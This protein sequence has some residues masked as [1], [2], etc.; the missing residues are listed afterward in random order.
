MA[1]AMDEAVAMRV[2][3]PTNR[4]PL[5]KKSAKA[6]KEAGYFAKVA[7]R[8]DQIATQEAALHRAEETLSRLE[9]NVASLAEGTER[10][11]AL[12]EVAEVSS[13]VRSLATEVSALKAKEIR[14]P[15]GLKRHHTAQWYIQGQSSRDF[16]GHSEKTDWSEWSDHWDQDGNIIRRGMDAWVSRNEQIGYS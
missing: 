7:Q 1:A 14:K 13:K 8:A 10:D 2:T 15:W 16:W 6:G 12:Q 5:A 9:A 3:G 4:R 11:T